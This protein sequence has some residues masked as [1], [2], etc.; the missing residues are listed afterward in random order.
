[1]NK[2][3]RLTFSK[4]ISGVKQ[5]KQLVEHESKKKSLNKDYRS[6]RDEDT[7]LNDNDNI[8]P[9]QEEI[10]PLLMTE[11]KNALHAGNSQPIRTERLRSYADVVAGTTHSSNIGDQNNIMVAGDTSAFKDIKSSAFNSNTTDVNTLSQ[12]RLEERDNEKQSQ[13]TKDF[14]PSQNDIAPQVNDASA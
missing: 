8:K 12:P 9:E 13:A 4:A 5:E 6:F 1:M 14:I 3:K 2:K 10:T 7:K 11:D